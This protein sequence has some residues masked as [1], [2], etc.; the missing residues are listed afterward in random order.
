M[1]KSTKKARDIYLSTIL[2]LGISE[3]NK[4][5]KNILSW[6]FSIPPATKIKQ[7]TDEVKK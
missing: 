2:Y 4:Y 6:N 3:T 1:K 7:R 5:R